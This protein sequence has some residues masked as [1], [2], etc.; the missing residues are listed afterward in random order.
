MR[1][2]DVRPGPLLRLGSAVAWRLPGR[3]AA[4]LVARSQAQ[5]GRGLE[6]L[7]ACEQTSRVD[8]RRAFFLHAMDTLRHSRWLRQRAAALATVRSRT[9]AVL[10]DSGYIARQGIRGTDPLFTELGE[11]RFLALVWLD[12]RRDLMRLVALQAPADPDP[13]T[14]QALAG[15]IQ[16]GRVHLAGVGAE[17]DRARLR[18][19]PVTW[20]LWAIRRRR[21]WKGWMD[22]SQRVGDLFA[23][24]WLSLLFLVVLAPFALLARLL[25]RDQ[26]GL[27]APEADPRPAAQRAREQA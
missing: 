20:A 5:A 21:A 3:P 13:A 9:T 6:L 23:G 7:E 19:E 15:I 27:V 1:D 24:L 4:T 14:A 11:L 25:E 2:E 22:L 8:L 18:G 10:E 26:P 17:L 12:R 16:E